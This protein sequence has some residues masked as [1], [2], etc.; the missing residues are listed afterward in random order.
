MRLMEKRLP[1]NCLLAQSAAALHGQDRGLWFKAL[2]DHVD[3]STLGR[4]MYPH[5]PSPGH[6]MG[7][8]SGHT[9]TSPQ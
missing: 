6:N 7:T 8:N 1:R 3:F 2:V 4:R 9:V 5:L